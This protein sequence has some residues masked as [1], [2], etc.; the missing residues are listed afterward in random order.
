M[1]GELWQDFEHQIKLVL[2]QSLDDEFSIVAEE[3]KAPTSA[4]ALTSFEDLIVIKTRAQT[5]LNHLK[6]I[7]IV[8]EG[9]HKNFVLVKLNF[10]IFMN[11]CII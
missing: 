8:L 10:Y 5:S 4:G 7:E 11:R 3:E 2:C 1:P 6:V 9:L